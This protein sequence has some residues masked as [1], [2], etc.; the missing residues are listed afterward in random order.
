MGFI[1]DALLLN[2]YPQN[3]TDDTLIVAYP[4]TGYLLKLHMFQWLHKHTENK[5]GKIGKSVDGEQ[6][7]FDKV[8]LK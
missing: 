6:I 7:F 5:R 8:E 1:N 2:Q 4:P 3:E